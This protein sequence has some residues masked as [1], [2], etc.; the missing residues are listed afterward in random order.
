MAMFERYN[1]VVSEDQIKANAIYET[2]IKDNSQPKVEKLKK[3][4]S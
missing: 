3:G 1:I 2:Y 4:A